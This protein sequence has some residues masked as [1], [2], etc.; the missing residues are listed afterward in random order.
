M[1]PGSL[2]SGGASAHVGGG[3]SEKIWP[4]QAGPMAPRKRPDSA[5]SNGN[6][7]RTY[8]APRKRVS[9]REVAVRALRQ[10]SPS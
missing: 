4:S 2:A 6:R 10:L 9:E 5:A 3:R 1:A 8:R 7:H